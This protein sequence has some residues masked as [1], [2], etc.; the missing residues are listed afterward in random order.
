MYQ[1]T[2]LVVEDELTTS[3]LVHFTLQNHHFNVFLAPDGAHAMD[4]LKNNKIDV[5]LLD[6]NLPDTTGFDFI[7]Q[8]KSHEKYKSIPIIVLTSSTDKLDV[9]LALEMGADDYITKP[10]HKREL[11]ARIHVALRKLNSTLSI[12]YSNLTFGKLRIDVE[13][14]TVFKSNKKIDLTFKEFEL[15]ILFATNPGKVF[16]RDEILTALWGYN[17]ITE[18]RTV[19]MHVSSLRKKIENPDENDFFIETVRGVGYRFRK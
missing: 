19:D 18:T 5:I 4:Y 11:I 17:Y 6:L 10:F 3:K 7:K 15:L 14:R 8:I 13:S 2:V 1:Q 12:N 9:V 16:S